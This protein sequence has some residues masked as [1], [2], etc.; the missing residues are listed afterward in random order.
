M[1]I[2]FLYLASAK[3][4]ATM[5]WHRFISTPP[6]NLHVF[7]PGAVIASTIAAN[8]FENAFRDEAGNSGSWLAPLCLLFR[9]EMR[10]VWLMQHTTNVMWCHI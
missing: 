2:G 5:R 9:D 7:L 6:E 1:T 8:I 3:P 10:G 4:R